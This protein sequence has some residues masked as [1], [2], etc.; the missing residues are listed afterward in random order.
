MTVKTI[1]D[2]L[3]NL[4]FQYTARTGPKTFQL[5][6]DYKNFNG[7]NT[8]RMADE[9]MIFDKLDGIFAGCLC[10]YIRA[11]DA[12][13]VEMFGRS[14]KKLSGMQ[15]LEDELACQLNYGQG[16]LPQTFILISEV[17]SDEPLA[18]LSGYTNPKRK[19]SR[20]APPGLANNYHE[21][22]T[23]DEFIKGESTTGAFTRYVDLDH[24]A[25]D[26]GFR[27]EL[28]PYHLG[29]LGEAKEMFDVYT[30]DGG[31]GVICRD[32]DAPY[33][34]GK[35]DERQFKLK[36][37]IEFECR[38]VG[39]AT[40]KEGSKYEDVVGKLLFAF[41]AFG[42]QDGELILLPVGSGLT[43]EQREYFMENPEELTMTTWKLKA[44]SY[45]EFGN[46]REPVIV[47]QRFDKGGDFVFTPGKLTTYRKALCQWTHYE[48][49]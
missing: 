24:V 17:T 46:V 31:E 33:E 2:S 40:G 27:D 3:G 29:N 25:D 13:H 16:N 35:K 43:D 23:V 30:A 6:K 39:F 19:D 14:G 11:D 21:F 45:T 42:K 20:S 10:I 22:I 32:P 18:K 47:E 48:I 7:A 38:C 44:K 37:K 9:F 34:A 49:N 41:R 8:K 36:E 5:A 1:W 15:P 12:Y 4:G 28:I 26:C